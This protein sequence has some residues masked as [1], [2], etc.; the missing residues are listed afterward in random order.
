M[1]VV[2]AQ[3][4]QRC[5][6]DN[7]SVA[8]IY[9]EVVDELTRQRLWLYNFTRVDP[10]LI[11]E[12]RVVLGNFEAVWEN[13]QFG[14]SIE[15]S[16]LDDTDNSGF[17]S[18][19]GRDDVSL[20]ELLNWLGG[21]IANQNQAFSREA[22]TT[23]IGV[24]VDLSEFLSRSDDLGL[25]LLGYQRGFGRWQAIVDVINTVGDIFKELSS[26][27]GNS[28]VSK[29]VLALLIHSSQKLL[30]LMASPL[31]EI[32]EFDEGQSE[33]LLTILDDA[34]GH[35]VIKIA[36]LVLF[37]VSFHFLICFVRVLSHL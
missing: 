11:V 37:D 25:W 3:K 32:F 1:S 29:I 36:G 15:L 35:L 20:F 33:L 22:S 7:G 5:S 31:L 28:R 12:D 6:V 34:F 9:Y 17:G 19:H 27:M 18:I 14:D 16:S 21:L 26:K 24:V 2:V 8:L 4:N 30:V 23:C 10:L 13:A